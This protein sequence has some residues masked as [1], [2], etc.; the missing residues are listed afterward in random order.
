MFLR[1]LLVD[2]EPQATAALKQLLD[3]RGH[4]VREENDSTQAL[5]TVK[6]FQPDVVILDYLMPSAH[7]GDVA[8]QIASDPQLK[9]VQ[10]VICSGVN[11]AEFK[12]KLPP[13]RIPIFEKPVNPDALLT[14]LAGANSE[15]RD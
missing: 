8:W 3:A 2:D 15:N 14:V 7:G 9:N 11:P 6:L 1:I 13:T 10:L 12:G 4:I 5:S